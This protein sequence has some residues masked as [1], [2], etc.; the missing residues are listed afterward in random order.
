V[1]LAQGGDLEITM[2]GHLQVLR[3]FC[4]KFCGFYFCLHQHATKICT[5]PKFPTIQNETFIGD[6][7]LSNCGIFMET[8]QWLS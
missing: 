2:E 4:R 8:L 3:F 6:N 1:K 5:V 7:W